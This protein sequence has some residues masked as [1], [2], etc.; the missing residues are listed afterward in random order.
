MAKAK[1]V[2]S[3]P[4]LNSSSIQKTDPPLGARAESVDSFSHQPGIGQPEG[5]NLASDSRK[6][7]KGLSRRLMLGGLAMLPAAL[8]AAAEAAADPIYAAI[9]ACREAREVADIAYSRT[10]ALYREAKEKFGDDDTRET[11]LLHRDYVKCVLGMDGDEYTDG[12]AFALYEAYDNFTL[13][14]PST[15]A[16]LFGMLIYCEEVVELNP[17]AFEFVDLVPTLAAAAKSLSKG[18]LA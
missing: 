14:E 7:A 17:D 13:T 9:A 1:R 16:G 15:L 3:T 10:S 5:P 4:P 12:P 6:P 18:G 11:R 8:P 2:H